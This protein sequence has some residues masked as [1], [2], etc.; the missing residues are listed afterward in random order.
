MDSKKMQVMDRLEALLE[1]DCCVAFSGGADSS[2]LLS[3]ACEA[4][5]KRGTK[6]F[7]V[8]LGTALHPAADRETARRVAREVGAQYRELFVDELAEAGIE[9]N[10]PDRCYRCK[11]LLFVRLLELARELGCGAVLEGTNGDDLGQYRPGLRAVRELGVISPLAEAGLSKEQVRAWARERGISVADRP[12]SPCMATRLPY[13]DRLELSVLKRIEAG[14]SYLRQAGFAQV[15]LRV[16]GQVARIEVMPDQ[17]EQVFK[18]AT[19]IV[20]ELR[21]LGFSYVTLDLQGFRSGSMDEQLSKEN[22]S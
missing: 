10:P 12:A 16:H 2:L 15:R 6:V 20:R 19:A 9:D 22:L 5:R 18:Q 1:E 4:A 17:F 11:R 13:G 7:G 14:E 3:L 21:A 8:L